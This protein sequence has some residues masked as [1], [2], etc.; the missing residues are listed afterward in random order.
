MNKA[1][2]AGIGI[3]IVLI[4]IAALMMNQTDESNTQVDLS[5]DVEITAEDSKSSDTLVVIEEGVKVGDKP[6]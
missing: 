4:A 5:E 3:G 6:P 2:A 1:V